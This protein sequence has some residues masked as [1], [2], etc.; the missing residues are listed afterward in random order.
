VRINKRLIWGIAL[1]AI[2]SFTAT[3]LRAP[4]AVMATFAFAMLGCLGYVLVEVILRGRA[5]TLEL[6]VV[7]IGLVFAVLVIGGVALDAAGIP[8]HP[9]AW[10]AL[11][12]GL[13]LVGDLVLL[14]R[15]RGDALED[16]AR[17]ESPPELDDFAPPTRPERLASLAAKSQTIP[18]GDNGESV[19]SRSGSGRRR[20]S[21]SHAVLYGLALIIAASALW[22][23]QSGA[24]TQQYGG[25]TELW[26][27][28]QP[29]STKLYNLGVSD[30]E[31]KTEEYR[32][33]LSRTKKKNE[34]WEISLSSGES[35]QRAVAVTDAAAANLY[36]LPDVSRPYRTVHTAMYG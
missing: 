11:L 25:Y 6:T 20:I 15:R 24:A 22:M 4:T 1:V 10:S 9:V 2:C 8:L 34:T 18:R 30:Q 17:Y 26:L 16:S 21:R 5:R 27:T 35:W 3:A 7:A 31:G 13:T 14:L 19:T 28:K 23:A 32:L 36:L 29:H 12:A 33:V